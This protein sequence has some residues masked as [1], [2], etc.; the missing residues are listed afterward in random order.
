[1]IIHSILHSNVDRDACLM[2]SSEGELL[3]VEYNVLYTSF[4]RK[5]NDQ[6]GRWMFMVCVVVTERKNKH[7]KKK[8]CIACILLWGKTNTDKAPILIRNERWSI[9]GKAASICPLKRCDKRKSFT[10]SF[11]LLSTETFWLSETLIE[12]YVILFFFFYVAFF[13]MNCFYEIVHLCVRRDW[14]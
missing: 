3:F 5:Q 6:R 1:M 10:N 7:K 9:K 14:N 12:L 4:S 8:L 2:C 13:L 11:I